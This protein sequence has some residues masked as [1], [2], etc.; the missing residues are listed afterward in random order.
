MVFWIFGILLVGGIFWAAFDKYGDWA[1]GHAAMCVIGGIGVFISIIIF[2]CSYTGIDGYIAANDARYESLVYQ[3][4]NN[5]YENDKD[6]GKKEL[7][8][9]IQTWNEDV[10]KKQANQDDFWIGIYIPDI[11]DHFKTIPLEVTE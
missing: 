11:Y 10:L 7:F 3:Y 8:D 1:L 6:I 5:V 2:I 9:D 4:E